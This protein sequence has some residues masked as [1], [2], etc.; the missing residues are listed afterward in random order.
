VQYRRWK[1][2][3]DISSTQQCV[4]HFGAA[5]VNLRHGERHPPLRE[6][7]RVARAVEHHDASES[8]DLPRLVPRGEAFH[9]IATDQQ[10]QGRTWKP[11]TEFTHRVDGVTRTATAYLAV[12]GHEPL[13]ADHHRL[14]EREPI[15]GRRDPTTIGLLPGVVSDHEVHGVEPKG[16]ARRLRD[17][18]MA[19]MRGIKRAAKDSEA[20]RH[21]RSLRFDPPPKPNSHA[22][23][24]RAGR[25]GRRFYRLA[26]EKC[27]IP[28]DF[29]RDNPV[30]SSVPEYPRNSPNPLDVT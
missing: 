20:G 14:H 8:P 19:P 4:A 6:R 15:C 28:L 25:V 13:M 5:H 27:N 9:E 1:I 23:S 16:R 12:I 22:V 24:P 29:V 18:Q 30:T 17:R 3:A 11:L 21:V 7:L 10:V 2:I 26:G